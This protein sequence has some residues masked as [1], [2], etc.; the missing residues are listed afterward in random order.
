MGQRR[1]MSKLITDDDNFINLSSSAQA[2]YMHLNLNADDDGCI[3]RAGQIIKC[4]GASNDDFKILQAKG[5]IL[6]IDDKVYVV[7]DWLINNVIRNDRKTPSIFTEQLKLLKVD[8]NKRY[9]FDAGTPL[10]EFTKKKE[11]SEPD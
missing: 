8:E 3:S 4:I 6:Q 5:Y 7:T 9:S 11:K 10:L 1:M 2:L